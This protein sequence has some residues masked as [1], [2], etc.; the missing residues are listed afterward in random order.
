MMRL[1]AM[2]I[3]PW[4]R[5]LPRVAALAASS[6]S[7][8]SST[9]KGALLVEAFDYDLEDLLDLTLNAA[10]AAFV[11]LEMRE[12]LVEYINDYYDNLLDDEEDYDEDEYE[13]VAD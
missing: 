7:A 4:C 10:E 3:C 1:I 13:N 8:S 2:Q 6:R 9:T 5:N 12:L 11:P